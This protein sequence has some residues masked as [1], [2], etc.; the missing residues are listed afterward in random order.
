LTREQIMQELRR[1]KGPGAGGDDLPPPTAPDGKPGDGPHGA[2]EVEGPDHPAGWFADADGTP[3]TPA[4]GSAVA[5]TGSAPA[6]SAAGGSGA[7]TGS[8]GSA[9][10]PIAQSTDVMPRFDAIEPPHV[11][12]QGP[13]PRASKA[14]G[15][16]GKD[17]IE[18]AFDQLTPA[19]QGDIL[20]SLSTRIFAGDDNSFVIIQLKDRHQANVAEFDKDAEHVL[21]EMRHRRSEAA[22]ADYLKARCEALAK[23]NR[24]KANQELVREHDDNGNPLPSGYRPCMSFQVQAQSQFV[25]TAE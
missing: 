21:A 13:M 15:I 17:I 14:G 22:V 8:A 10:D 5:A 16:G 12:E 20:A 23:S 2:L 19:S 18:A 6:G 25:P 7:G 4:P 24:I 1:L 11:S 9:V 3:G